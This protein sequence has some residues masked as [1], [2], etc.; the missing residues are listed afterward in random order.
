MGSMSKQLF[1]ELEI[2]ALAWLSL[3]INGIFKVKEESCLSFSL[4]AIM[5][6]SNLY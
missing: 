4:D 6:D 1:L 5:K 2:M 3:K